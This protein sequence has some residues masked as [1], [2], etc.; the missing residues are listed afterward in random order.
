MVVTNRDPTTTTCLL[1]DLA[2]GRCPTRVSAHLAWLSS[3]HRVL[4][5]H[6]TTAAATAL[7]SRQPSLTCLRCNTRDT[8]NTLVPRLPCT[9]ACLRNSTLTLVTTTHTPLPTT[10]STLARVP[11]RALALNTLMHTLVLPATTSLPSCHPPTW[12]AHPLRPLSVPRPASATHQPR[13]NQPHRLPRL[14]HRLLSRP[15][16]SFVLLRRAA[17]SRSPTTVVKPCLS[18]SL[19]LL[20]AHSNLKVP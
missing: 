6:P 3:F 14:L 11:H 5:A 9:L 20:P 12:H 16:T 2:T 19:R 10:T 17:R 18:R 15:R 8:L 4:K 7:L 1:P 13:A